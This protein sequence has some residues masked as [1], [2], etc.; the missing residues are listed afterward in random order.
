MSN[1]RKQ[2]AF[3][4]DP[5]L[6]SRFEECDN[7]TRVLNEALRLYFQTTEERQTMEDRLANLEDFRN[8]FMA[9]FARIDNQPHSEFC[10]CKNCKTTRRSF[11]VTVPL[12]HQPHARDKVIDV[13]SKAI[14]QAR[15][16]NALVTFTANNYVFTVDADST[17][18]EEYNRYMSFVAQQDPDTISFSMPNPLLK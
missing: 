2:V 14:E 7:K 18:G 16:Q 5:E 12:A 15:Q 11:K 1:E 17:A 8:R 6:V 3:W 13:I 10:D 4:L 9:Y